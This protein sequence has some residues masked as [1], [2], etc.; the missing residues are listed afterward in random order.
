M[1]ARYEILD[2]DAELPLTGR[3]YVAKACCEAAEPSQEADVTPPRNGAF[4]LTCPTCN[5]E[6]PVAAQDH[7]ALY[8]RCDPCLAAYK[9]ET[10]IGG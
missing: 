7:R 6:L 1:D 9:L 8:F 5:Q 2:M 10:A 3:I 4:T